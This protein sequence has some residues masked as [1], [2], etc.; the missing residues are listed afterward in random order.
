[1]R[2]SFQ[3]GDVRVGV[4]LGFAL[5]VA[6]VGLSREARCGQLEW[7]A[8]EGCSADAFVV[9]LRAD[10]QRS[11]EEMATSAVIVRVSGADVSGGDWTLEFQL[12]NAA[13]QTSPTREIV[14]V[15]CAD[16]SRAG[17]VAVSIALAEVEP[18]VDA[19]PAPQTRESRDDVGNRAQKTAPRTEQGERVGAESEPAND[20]PSQVI[21]GS[22]GEQ[23]LWP[24]IYGELSGDTSV[25]GAPTFA[26]GI[27]GG[28][29]GKAWDVGL[30]GAIVRST[31]LTADDGLG[32]RLSGYWAEAFGCVQLSRTSRPS[33]CLGY[34]LDVARGEGRG[35]GFEVTRVQTAVRSGLHPHVAISAP[36]ADAW[37][38]R[39][40]AG[41]VVGL[42]QPTFVYDGGV[43]AHQLPRVSFRGA[44]SVVWGR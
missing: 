44:V 5:A 33:A 14:G 34:A 1:M 3:A 27:G 23:T 32:I 40:R 18:D 35:S 17:A 28:V 9:H 39:F 25:L 21:A 13:G 15:S 19:E 38:V 22:V 30:R 24:V 6:G 8:P 16:V 7:S 37:E 41:L 11:I 12:R 10:T 29:A 42:N 2:L 31:D 43:V 26:G 4:A 36:L 20:T